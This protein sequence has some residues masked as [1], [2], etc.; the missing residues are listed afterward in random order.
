MCIVRWIKD[1]WIDRQ[2]PF[3]TWPEA[4]EFADGLTNAS[5]IEIDGYPKKIAERLVD[6]FDDRHVLEKEP[7]QIIECLLNIIDGGSS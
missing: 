2:E 5:E 6:V 7:E 3:G 1:G 4:K